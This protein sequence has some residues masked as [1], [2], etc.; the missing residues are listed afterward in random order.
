LFLAAAAADDA[1]DAT[2]VVPGNGGD[3][4]KVAQD[5]LAPNLER[6]RGL[7]DIRHRFVFS[8]V[9]ELN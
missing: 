4:A 9:A 2:S 1:P 8:A 7:N 6:G 5:T 3:D